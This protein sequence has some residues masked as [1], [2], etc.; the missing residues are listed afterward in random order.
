MWGG[1]LIGR[2]LDCHLRIPLL[3]RRNL[4]IS[5]TSL[6]DVYA[7]QRKISHTEYK[8]VDIEPLI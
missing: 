7:R 5:F 3:L 8:H 1:Q 4:A 6:F 2:I